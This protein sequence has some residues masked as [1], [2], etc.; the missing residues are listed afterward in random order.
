MP[1]DSSHSLYD[2][3]SRLERLLD[4]LERVLDRTLA[5][6]TDGADV[7]ASW[8]AFRWVRRDGR[9]WLEAIVHPDL[10]RLDDLIG[11]DREL[12]ILIRNTEQF[13]RGLPANNVLIWGERGTGKSS[14]VKGLLTRFA[15]EGLRMIEVHKHDLTDLPLIVEPLWERPERFI[16]F[17]DD[18]SFDEGESLYKELKAMLEGGL[19]ARPGNVLI[20]ATSNRRHLMPERFRDNR[21]VFSDEDGEIHPQEG[22]E[23]KVS[24]SDRFGLSIGFYGIDQDTYLR[25]VTHWAAQRGLRV[26][27]D[28]LRREALQWAQRA[29]G[30][31]GRVA[32][33]FIDDLAGRL[34]LE[35]EK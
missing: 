14:T 7:F 11:L 25:I 33:Q 10:A 28:T 30:R 17:C 21:P 32:R 4:K 35:G 23:E 29:S 24:L 22:A 16:L 27:P 6:R 26:A 9:G 15:S 8:V 13:V 19:A 12:A 18:L 1:Q 34:G 31:S 3:L 2:F 20:Y 5:G